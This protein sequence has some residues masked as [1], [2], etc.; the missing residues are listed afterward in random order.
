MYCIYGFWWRVRSETSVTF[1]LRGTGIFLCCAICIRV[2]AEV[3]VPVLRVCV[4]RTG[5]FSARAMTRSVIQ[6]ANPLFCSIVHPSNLRLDIMLRGCHTFLLRRSV[7][8]ASSVT[9]MEFHD[10]RV[11]FVVYAVNANKRLSQ[12]A[13]LIP[14]VALH[15]SCAVISSAL[16][17]TKIK[18]H[19]NSN[20]SL[21][22]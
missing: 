12:F 19:F 10:Q 22:S 15:C 13:N 7:V 8:R 20:Y 16:N 1:I 3:L 11:I 14:K 18:S 17:A 5:V 4:A 6:Q 9:P 21:F 2:P